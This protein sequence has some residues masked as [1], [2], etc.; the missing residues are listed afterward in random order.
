MV[1][2]ITTSAAQ[3]M[4]CA[5]QPPGSTSGPTK[6]ISKRPVRNGKLYQDDWGSARRRWIRRIRH[7]V[8]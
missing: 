3:P 2:I 4:I 8:S 1:P 6:A 7:A 5:H